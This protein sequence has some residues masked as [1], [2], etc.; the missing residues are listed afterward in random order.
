MITRNIEIAR[1]G[2]EFDRESVLAVLAEKEKHRDSPDLRRAVELLS[3]KIYKDDI[4]FI[5]ELIQNAEDEYAD[6]LSIYLDK[7]KVIVKNNGRVFSN[8][9]VMEICSIGGGS[10]KNK[11]GF[12]GIGF[13]SVFQITDSPQV[14]SGRYN[15]TIHDY[16]YPKPQEHFE[17]ESFEYVPESGAIFILPLNEE[18]RNDIIDFSERL[19]DVDEKVLLF[20]SNLKKI[21]F[22]DATGDSVSTWSYEKFMEGALESVSNTKTG[23]KNTWRVFRK[24]IEVDDPSLIEKIEE[25]EGIEITAIVIAFP[26][27]DVE[28]I[29]NC[30]SEP[31]YCYLPTEK[32]AQ[33]P[34]I[35]QADFIPNAGR[36][37]I[38][39]KP[40]WNTWLFKNL[41]KHA[42]ESIL[43]LR[44]EDSYF[45]LFYELI[46][47]ADDYYDNELK[48]KFLSPFHNYLRNS[49]TVYGKDG[50]WHKVGESALVEAEMDKLIG[51]EECRAIYS[52]DIMPASVSE[53]TNS[54]ND[55]LKY[56]DISE[57]D[58]NDIS[59]LFYNYRSAKKRTP[60][61]FID[62]YYYLAKKRQGYDIRNLPDV[63]EALRKVP[64]LLSHDGTLVAP[65]IENESDRL[66]TYHPREE[67]LGILPKI[68]ED[69]E[70]V[71]LHKR[72]AS[73]EG[74]KKIDEKRK[75]IREFFV[76]QYDVSRYIDPHKIINDVILPKFENG[77]YSKYS[78]KKI[79]VLTN[80]I[81]ENVKYWINKKK[82]AR[83][84]VD[85]DDLYRELGKRLYLKVEWKIARKSHTGFLHPAEAYI[86]GRRNS[87]TKIYEMF[88]WMDETPFISD[89]Y[90]NPN[91]VRGYSKADMVSRG[92]TVRSIAWDEFFHK[93][94]AWETPRVIR[95]SPVYISRYSR[96]W[97][98]IDEMPG[99]ANDSGYSISVDWIM[100]EFDKVIDTF[101]HKPRKGKRLL[102]E[103][104]SLLKSHWTNYS[105]YKTAT[106][107]W[108]YHGHQSR[109]VDNCSFLY[110]MQITNWLSVNGNQPAKPEK[111]FLFS[112]ENKNLLPPD[113][114]FIQSDKYVSFYRDIGVQKKPEKSRVYAYL[115]EIKKVWKQNHF[116]DN[117]SD[118]LSDVYSFLLSDDSIGEYLPKL[119]K[120]K[121][122]FFPTRDCLWWRPSEA[123]WNDQSILF[124]KRRIYLNEYYP[125][126]IKEYFKLLG[127]EDSPSIESCIAAISEL[128]NIQRI[129]Y[130]II[131]YIN[132]IYRYLDKVISLKESIDKAVLYQPIYISK[133]KVFHL[134]EE[135]L[136]V[137][138]PWY[139]E[140][141]ID[142][143]HVLYLIY[144]YQPVRHLLEVAG[145]PT[146]SGKYSIRCRFKNK[147][148]CTNPDQ[149]PIRSLGDH[150][151]P[152][153]QYAHPDMTE[154]C[155]QIMEK[156]KN[157]TVYNVDSLHLQLVNNENIKVVDEK[158][159]IDAYLQRDERDLNLLL[160]ND[161]NSPNNHPNSISHEISKLFW[162]FGY[163]ELKA[164]IMQLIECSTGDERNDVIRGYGIPDEIID[165]VT[166]DDRHVVLEGSQM[167]Q[168]GRG[169][170]KVKKEI[171]ILPATGA[172]EI[173]VIETV[174]NI[175]YRSYE[176]ITH[177]ITIVNSDDGIEKYSESVIER[178][179]NIRKAVKGRQN[180]TANI[181]RKN[182]SPLTTEAY[183]LNIVM[184]FEREAGREPMDVHGQKGIGYDIKSKERYIE[185]KSFRGQKSRISLTPIEYQAGEK[186]SDKYYLYIVSQLTTEFEEIEIEMIQNPIRNVAF[187]VTGNRLAKKYAGQTT[188]R[189]SCLPFN[190]K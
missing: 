39:T 148:I 185:V 43:Q 159:N 58:I 130:E 189:L 49:K 140:F 95:N 173:E 134:P 75:L 87:R 45:R 164:V 20:L 31:L 118:I 183:A 13:K 101:N 110:A 153:I 89:E 11:I 172:S 156:L 35:L 46:P 106:I 64:F 50:N 30:K 104:I 135:L 82:S 143:A 32:P 40:Q 70:L 29:N 122:I 94:G 26:E 99:Q 121:S 105:K 132:D 111:Y 48:D 7:N 33:L 72:L 55:V 76:N 60:D 96:S 36:N 170:K 141:D 114:L 71:F 5:L 56:Y 136:F 85:M 166:N 88:S 151:V 69:G 124:G 9:D 8:K 3:K 47:I 74:E 80:Y 150:L 62:I 54:V 63:Y 160:I 119:R 14:I 147:S 126:K 1:S 171:I 117:Y 24:P 38:D 21:H 12:M 66:V 152:Y 182:T 115:K 53:F 109:I 177:I 65:F 129:D 2:T 175:E 179:K 187:E 10:K 161:G 146:I 86:S 18:Y 120:Y 123:F 16:L 163:F 4:H 77:V 15:F 131:K 184:S 154:Q 19:F 90:Y 100:P 41:A 162:Q 27:P 59:Q 113:T 158:K 51:I 127:V 157:I 6:E 116:P 190:E 67:D 176:E 23:D 91:N 52:G 167:E 25:K 133:K 92:R 73:A 112:E 169:H 98:F 42:A 174:S 178:R 68:F 186:Y 28:S 139:N 34:F 155:I 61:W 168:Q 165:S 93:M 83:T 79:V 37:D 144:S 22:I 149:E 137:D 138:D 103:F 102:S 125:V 17:I 145:V 107:E 142:D 78:D 181:K 180:I 97:N 44:G 108:S 84:L 188:I 81:R 57:V 128:H